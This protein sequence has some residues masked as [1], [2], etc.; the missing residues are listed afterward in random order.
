ME[1][2]EVAVPV[3]VPVRP[4]NIETIIS[5]RIQKLLVYLYAL[6]FGE[7]KVVII[8]GIWVLRVKVGSN[9]HFIIPYLE[10]VDPKM[11]C[12]KLLAAYIWRHKTCHSGSD[13]VHEAG[14]QWWWLCSRGEVHY[15][16]G[17]DTGSHWSTHGG[18]WCNCGGTEVC[19]LSL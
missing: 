16:D 12:H 2:D 11:V 6:P 4:A 3:P 1:A 13:F 19:N 17:K 18:A 8:K 15:G 5:S 7:G 14:G 10:Y 9:T